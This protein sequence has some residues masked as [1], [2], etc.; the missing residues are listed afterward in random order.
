M[1]Q[2]SES[3]THPAPRTDDTVLSRFERWVRDTP[4]A[5]A[6]AAGAASLTYGQLDT[7]ANQLAHHLLN[8]GL[9]DR[10][11]V[12]VATASRSELLVG[13][14]AVLKAGAA[15]TVIDVGNPRAGR[16]QIAAARPFALLAD[17][18]DQARLDDG[19]DLPVIRLGA[20]RAVQGGTPP[21]RRPAPRERAPPPS[22]SPG[23]PTDGPSASATTCSSPPTRAG[24]GWPG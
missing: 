9:P 13:L 23:A 16:L 19:G 6:V 3:S 21:N 2:G 15:Y 20:E 5:Q 11:V 12:A 8:S 7:R 22:C 4:G 18:L 1:T 14:L 10:A 17:A 24:P